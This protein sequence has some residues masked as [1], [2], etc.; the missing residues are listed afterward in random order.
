MKITQIAAI[1]IAAGINFRSPF[2][3]GEGNFKLSG[4]EVLRRGE[5]LMVR[6]Q[7]VQLG[8]QIFFAKGMNSM[9]AFVEAAK[10]SQSQ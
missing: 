6:V 2:L 3:A 7:G 9:G 8:A 4:E 5:S 10:Q 1:R